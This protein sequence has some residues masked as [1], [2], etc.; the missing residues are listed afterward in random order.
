[1]R[2][3]D[4]RVRPDRDWQRAA[5]AAVASAVA[6]RRGGLLAGGLE[7]D[8]AG[9]DTPAA[10]FFRAARVLKEG[11]VIAALEDKAQVNALLAK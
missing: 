7:E 11:S 2:G 3:G 5:A 4:G 8:V 1:M 6:R 9:A 10:H